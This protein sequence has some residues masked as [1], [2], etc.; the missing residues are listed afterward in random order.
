MSNILAHFILFQ[1]ELT[2]NVI[3]KYQRVNIP[4]SITLIY[5]FKYTFMV[6]ALYFLPFWQ[7]DRVALQL[8]IRPEWT[9]RND[10]MPRHRLLSSLSFVN[11]L[12]VFRIRFSLYGWMACLI[13]VHTNNLATICCCLRSHAHTHTHTKSAF[14]DGKAMW[15]LK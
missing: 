8:N 1:F 5:L 14:G 7:T 4:N 11:Y 10:G 6:S 3:G 9:L 12:A 13:N 15:I 2:P